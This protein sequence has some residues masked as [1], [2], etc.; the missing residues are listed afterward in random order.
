MIK[1]L[2]TL[3]ILCVVAGCS[4][5]QYKKSYVSSIDPNTVSRMTSEIQ[6]TEPKLIQS[7]DVDNDV[8]AILEQGN[9][10]IIGNSLFNGPLEDAENAKKHAK[11]IG[12]THVVYSSEHTETISKKV[13]GFTKKG[14]TRQKLQI[15][16][17]ASYYTPVTTSGTVSRPYTKTIKLYDQQAVFLIKKDMKE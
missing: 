4:T 6:K 13:P 17:Q 16:G 8:S 9:Y 2:S 1:L 7:S 12:A 15:D 5:S 3:F 14:T 10:V 11:K